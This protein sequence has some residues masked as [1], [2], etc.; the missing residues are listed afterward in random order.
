MA[1]PDPVRNRPEKPSEKKETA[2]ELRYG[3]IG[4]PAIRAAT[5]HGSSSADQRSRVRP[6]VH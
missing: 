2:L 3:R 6:K 4:M 1:E 5:V